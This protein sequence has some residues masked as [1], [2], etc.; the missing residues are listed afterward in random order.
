MA[1]RASWELPEELWE[2]L[3]PRLP[4]LNAQRGRPRTVDLKRIAAGIFFVLRTGIHWH[5]LP[6]EQFGPSSTLYYYFRQWE[7]AGVF[8]DTWAAAL[9]A[10][11]EA[12]GV[13]W[14]WQ[15][16]DGCMTKAPLGGENDW[17]ESDRPQQVGDEAQRAYGRRRD[18]HRHYGRWRQS[19]RPDTVGRDPRRDG[20][21]TPRTERG[22]AAASLS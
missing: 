8:E 4:V 19:P 2:L 14:S 21:P 3:E 12:V 17:A 6:R 22:A 18:T 16:V 5:A 9:A 1:A 7:E 20:D 11:D 15:S 10:Y 13:D